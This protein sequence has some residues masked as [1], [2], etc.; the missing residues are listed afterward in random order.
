[1]P[2][3]EFVNPATAAHI[4]CRALALLFEL[5]I[6]IILI[7]ISAT[8]GYTNG[9]KY[10]GVI[11]AVLFDSYGSS[12]RYSAL[13]EKHIYLICAV[14]AIRGVLIVVSLCDFCLRR[15]L[16]GPQAPR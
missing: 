7:Y 6:L 10:A 15:R 12:L 8:E 9:V 4:L 16:D 5:A 11:C 3:N 1:M 14:L 2:H 13:F